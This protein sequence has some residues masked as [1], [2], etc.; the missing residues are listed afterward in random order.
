MSP[1][2][3]GLASVASMI[4]NASSSNAGKAPAARRPA[5]TAEAGPASV[6]HLSS[7]AQALAGAA[8]KALTQSAQAVATAATG[9]G[10]AATGGAQGSG[11]GGSVSKQDF[12]SLLTQFG[13]TEAQKEQLA[14]GLDANKDGAISR[15]EFL[16]G[17]A[18][19]QGS[20]A[21]SE[22]SQALMQVMDGAGNGGVASPGNGKGDGAVSAKEFAALT[23]AF[24]ALEKKGVKTV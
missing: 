4:F 14:T 2:I 10:A 5:D 9:A 24:A 1:L 13:A 20:K 17:L 22:L 15:D 23:T 21:G 19:T 18:N 7:Q 12:Q 8:G 11:Q 16:Q 3:S 6:V